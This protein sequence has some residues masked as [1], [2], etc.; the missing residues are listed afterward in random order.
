LLIIIL[1]IWISL[2]K[3]KKEEEKAKEK[4]KEWELHQQGLGYHGKSKKNDSDDLA[5]LGL[6]QRTKLTPKSKLKGDD[7]NP[8]TGQSSNNTDN[9]GGSCSYRPSRKSNNKGGWG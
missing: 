8:L 4:I 2:S 7:Y 1:K 9:G 5:A 6:S 3:F